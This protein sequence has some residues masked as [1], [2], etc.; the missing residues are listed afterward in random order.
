MMKK[1]ITLLLAIVMIVGCLVA[2]NKTPETSQNGGKET[3]GE[4]PASTPGN[5]D[6]GNDDPGNSE[7]QTPPEKKLNLDLE[8]LDYGGIDFNVYHW[9]TSNP[10]FGV[11]EDPEAP[12]EARD[13]IDDALYKRNL[14]TEEGLGIK[15]NFHGEPGGD[16]QQTSFVSTL[17]N[18][19]QNPDTPVDLIAS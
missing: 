1:I 10:E 12:D 16:N 2:C 13:P 15:L 19:I 3:P 6:P 4:T 18:R 5:G 8:E 17:K 7:D 14:Y 9:Q 11:V